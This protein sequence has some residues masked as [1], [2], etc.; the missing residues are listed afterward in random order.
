VSTNEIG[1][2]LGLHGVAR[3][4]VCAV[5]A[6]GALAFAVALAL[7]ILSLLGAPLAPAPEDPPARGA[8]VVTDASPA[9]E[10]ADTVETFLAAVPPPEAVAAAAV[11][12]AEAAAASEAMAPPPATP[13]RLAALAVAPASA[14]DA[15]A[16][17][18]QGALGAV[19]PA[20]LAA[21]TAPD[22]PS[23][24]LLAERVPLPPPAPPR[25]APPPAPVQLL[26]LSPQARAKAEA[27]LAR[28]IYFE[29]RSEPLRGQLAVAQVV[30]NRVFS[31][32]YP[33]DVCGVIYQ[34]AHRHLACQFTFACDGIRKRVTDHRAWARARRIAKDA[35]DGK[36]WVAE[37]GKSTHY[38]AAY[39]RPVWVRDMR[40]MVRFGLHTFYRPRNWGD[41]SDE[42]DWSV[43]AQTATTRTR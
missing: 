29:A 21:R 40:R 6:A 28:A 39:V 16:A 34:N 43:V 11:D 10:P 19:L 32:Y 4:I 38:H 33:N 17:A 2:A 1:L 37:V 30:M 13:L 41:G 27:C 18:A 22:E 42:Q 36:I 15:A 3:R 25:P 31:P 23:P 7:A 26:N 9:P 24:A 14:P 35:L 12:A 5:G 20:A 8:A